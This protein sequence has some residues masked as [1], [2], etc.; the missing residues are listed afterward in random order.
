M[1]NFIKNLFK[2]EE[3]VINFACQS[4]G[5]RKYAPIQPAGKFFPDKFKELS[6]YYKKEQYNIRYCCK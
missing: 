5:V 3:P 6:P 2:K 1:I 4:W